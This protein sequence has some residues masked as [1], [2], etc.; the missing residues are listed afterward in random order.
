MLYVKTVNPGMCTKMCCAFLEQFD[1]Y[2][3]CCSG[4][5][6]LLAQLKQ[7]LCHFLM[8][9]TF[10]PRSGPYFLI[11]VFPL[12]FLIAKV[13]ARGRKEK[14]DVGRTGKNSL[15]A[16]QGA[17][18]CHK[19]IATTK[20][21]SMLRCQTCYFRYEQALSVPQEIRHCRSPSPINLGERRE[22]ICNQSRRTIKKNSFS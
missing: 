15:A 19:H 7:T 11:L 6:W 14:K 22:F 5:P 9:R 20:L 1:S 4:I 16:V 10:A 17:E 12:Y 8:K 21:Y 2:L 18:T 3:F 13:E